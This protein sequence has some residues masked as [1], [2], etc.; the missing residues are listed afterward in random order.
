MCGRGKLKLF[1]V[2]FMELHIQVAG[3]RGIVT[4]GINE[5]IWPSGRTEN[6]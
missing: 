4:L 3:L 6:A 5:L 2:L 1:E